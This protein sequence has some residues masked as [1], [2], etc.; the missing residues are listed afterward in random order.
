[1]SNNDTG[2]GNLSIRV[3]GVIFKAAVHHTEN[4]DEGTL[5]RATFKL[6]K[7]SSIAYRFEQQ[8]HVCVFL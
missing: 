2:H 1:M 8:S 7:L 5:T 6:F 3:C 4:A